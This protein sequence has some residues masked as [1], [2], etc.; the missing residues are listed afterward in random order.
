M[1]SSTLPGEE[2]QT[3]PIIEHLQLTVPLTHLRVQL[4]VRVARRVIGSL[5]PSNQQV[6]K[7]WGGGQ[8]K[9]TLVPEAREMVCAWRNPGGLLEEV[10]LSCTR[11]DRKVWMIRSVPNQVAASFIFKTF[12]QEEAL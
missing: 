6:G 5:P 8:V 7:G 3:G 2:F 11:K 4:G 9:T 12:H 10:A 1:F